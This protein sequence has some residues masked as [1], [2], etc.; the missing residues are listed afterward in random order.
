AGPGPR[1]PLPTGEAAWVVPGVE[2]AHPLPPLPQAAAAGTALASTAFLSDWLVVAPGAAAGD[3]VR[4][5]LPDLVYGR[6]RSDLGDLRLTV[7]GRQIPYVRWSPAEPVLVVTRRGQQPLQEKGRQYSRIQMALPGISLPLSALHLSTPSL[8][9]RRPVG[10]RYPEPGPPSLAPREER[11]VRRETWECVPEPPLP[12]RLLLPLAVPSTRHLAVRFAD[13]D[14]PPLAALDVDLWRRDDV[15]LFAWPE[16]APVHLLT[17][18]PALRPPD[19]DLAALA[20]VLPGL[21]WLPAEVRLSGDPPAGPAPWWQRWILPA[22]LS[23]ATLGLLL[24]LRQI[25]NGA[26]P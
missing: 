12:C 21:P 15:L 16:R 3:L 9:L 19:Y 20:P 6:S 25:L 14:N 7:S 17:G 24:L 11:V 8:P 10:V 26:P 4:L 2:Q 18:N 23:L 13:G 5:P 22:T 1:P